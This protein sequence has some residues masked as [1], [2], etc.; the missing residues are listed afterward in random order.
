MHTFDGRDEC[1]SNYCMRTYNT[2]AHIRLAVCL[3]MY[4]MN[5]QGGEDS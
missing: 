2:N 3:Q 4:D 1:V 5:I